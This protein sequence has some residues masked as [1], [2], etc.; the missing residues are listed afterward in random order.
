MEITDPKYLQSAVKLVDLPS[1]VLPEYAFA[2]RSNVGKSTLINMLCKRN[3]LAITSSNPGR[4]QTI[5]HFLIDKNWYLVDLPGYGFAKV[6]KKSREAWKRMIKNYLKNRENLVSV[7]LLI[8][9]R[10]DPMQS[11]L[12]IME[13]LGLE[14]IPFVI[15]FTK[16][17]QL[18]QQ[19]IAKTLDKYKTKLKESWEKL[20]EIVVSS[21][22]KKLGRTN[23]L[24]HIAN[25]NEVFRLSLE[26]AD[27]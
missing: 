23:I 17:D 18:K 16:S 1:P 27:E 9:I 14:G 6:S 2:G 21:A 3:K 13:M 19:E 4:T 25:G 26:S 12:E 15:V 20:P 24:E 11:D 5:N 7:F 10:V 8:D 22:K